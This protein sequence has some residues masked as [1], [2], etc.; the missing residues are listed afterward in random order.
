MSV[1][2]EFKAWTQEFQRAQTAMDQ[3][4]EKVAAAFDLIEKDLVL[5]GASAI[6]DK[7]Q[8]R[9]PETIQLLRMASVKFWMLTGDKY[10]TALQVATACNLKS[11]D[12]RTKLAVVEG[13]D[14]ASIGQCIDDLKRTHVREEIMIEGHEEHWTVSH[15]VSQTNES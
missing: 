6:E 15:C 7:L 2:A 1:Q 8:E 5:Q 13:N 9:V 10:S 11:A 14:A 12:D 3:R 4:K